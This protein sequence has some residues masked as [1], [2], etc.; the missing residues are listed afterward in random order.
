MITEMPNKG[1][2]VQASDAVSDNAMSAAKPTPVAADE[3]ESAKSSAEDMD[4]LYES[5]SSG[6]L[7]PRLSTASKA[8]IKKFWTD[9]K[10]QMIADGYRSD[11]Q[12]AEDI[13]K[14]GFF[15]WAQVRE[16]IPEALDTAEAQAR[17]DYY[18]L[19]DGAIFVRCAR[20]VVLMDQG[21]SVIA[22]VEEPRGGEGLA[23]LYETGDILDYK[24]YVRLVD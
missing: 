4:K 3:H 19:P 15:V 22:L 13:M 12:A 18:M 9:Y 5:D 16:Y 6:G 10:N 23:K 1:L 8:Y 17:D 21:D 20:M 2:T 24:R 7:T 14:P 11:R